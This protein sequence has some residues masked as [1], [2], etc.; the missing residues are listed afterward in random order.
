MILLSENTTFSRIHFFLEIFGL[1]FCVFFC[2]YIL[3]VGFFSA[4]SGSKIFLD[5]IDLI[6]LTDT[7]RACSISFEAREALQKEFFAIT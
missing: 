3:C 5:T 1:S 4:D 7:C 2:I 6:L